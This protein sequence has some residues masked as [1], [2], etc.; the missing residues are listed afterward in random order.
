MC[1]IL[2]KLGRNAPAHLP[3]ET[4]KHRGPDACGSWTNGRNCTLGH[5][6]L[7]ILDPDPRANQPMRD[8][9]GRFTLVFNGE[10]YNYA[11]LRRDRLKGVAFR[12]T[13]DTEV[14]LNLW[15]RYG[16]D[17][18]P[19]LRGM[20]AF[21]VWDERTE[22]LYLVR[23]RLGKKP[24]FY[25]LHGDGLAFA[26]EL[27]ALR[28]LLRTCPDVSAPAIDLFLGYQF[29]PAPHTIY[30]GVH[31]LRPA[32]YGVWHAGVWQEVRY[33]E[34][35]FD[36]DHAIG[37][38]DALTLLEAQVREAT[39][40]RLRS[41][42]PVGVLLSGGVDSS[43]VAAMAAQEYGGT[44]K[45]FSMG[46]HEETF[47]ELPFAQRVADRYATDHHA[48]ILNEEAEELLQ[49]AVTCY[50]EPF[51]DKSALP[52]MLVCR[53]A[54]KHVKVVL[55]GDGGDE[56]LA[57]YK[58]YAVGA[59]KRGTGP[60][61]VTAAALGRGLDQVST[62]VGADRGLLRKAR[63]TLPPLSQVMHFDEFLQP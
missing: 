40:L 28:P 16:V 51:G 3:L 18:L 13:S 6:R 55:N 26:S 58:K 14:L 54:A 46:F 60:W 1:G 8:L 56:L 57:G 2:G 12:S 21:A 5:T 38:E 7:A 36:P 37:D 31:K 22:S 20:F 30:H 17:A 27:C 25:S 63:A 45:T 11:E 29:I 19:L 32:H 41:D 47:N 61:A 52:S 59:L 24:L 15:A 62:Y 43:L 34:L 44:L 49:S 42:V 10:I 39:R 4:P 33:W 9:S 53:E 35:T 48:F 50:G 23:D